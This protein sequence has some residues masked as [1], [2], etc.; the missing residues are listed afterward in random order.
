M[1]SLRLALLVALL[2]V[3]GH[4]ISV[5]EDQPVPP[6]YVDPDNEAEDEAAPEQPAVLC[7]GQNCLAPENN[8]AQ[9]CEGQDCAPAPLIEQVE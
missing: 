2:I 1:Q 7:E 8:P 5:A 9:L 6:V 3:C 4:S